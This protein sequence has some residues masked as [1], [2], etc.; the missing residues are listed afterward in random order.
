MD[1]LMWVIYFCSLYFSIFWLLVLV[2]RLF[3]EKAAD[4]EPFQ[5]SVSIIIPAY[6]EEKNIGECI[7]S[8]LKLDYPREKLEIIVV[9]DGSQDKTRQI[10]ES[11]GNKIRLINLKD[12]SGTKATPVNVGLKKAGGEIVGCLDADSVVE[13]YTLKRMLPYFSEN[14]GAVTPALKVYKPEN[15]LQKLQW[16][17]YIF[18]I[19]LRKLMSLIDCIYVTPGPFSLYRK[20]ALDK[21]GDFDEKNITEDM[22]MALRLQANQYAIKNAADA[23]V[24]TIAPKNMRDLFSQRRRWYQG[25]LQNSLKYRRLFFN[26]KYGDFGLM[27]PMNV[28]SV[29]ILLTTTVLF[30]YYLLEPI[31]DNFFKLALVD[32]DVL[33]YLESIKISIILLDFDFTKLFVI[34]FV[35]LVGVIGIILSHRMANERVRKYGVRPLMVFM[36]FYFIFLGYLWFGSIVSFLGGTR[37]KW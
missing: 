21:I 23:F 26:R 34:F 33:T 12:N 28:L 17:E 25:L 3:G 31:I 36:M 13:S 30:T 11:F 9:N 18:S 14:V 1:I 5:P 15:L 20:E 19:L 35:A 27:M 2:E 32:F 4:G 29:I 10:C 8:L 6:N 37:E 16:F 7:E 24:W 22:E